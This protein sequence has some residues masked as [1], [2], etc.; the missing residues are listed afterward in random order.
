[1]RGLCDACEGF[2]KLPPYEKQCRVCEHRM[3]PGQLRWG[4][5]MCDLCWD[6]AKQ[7]AAT[8][9]AGGA[10]RRGLGADVCTVISAQLVFY[11]APSI[12]LPS[13]YLQIQAAANT[14]PSGWPQPEH[15]YAAVLTT[16]TVVSMVSPVPLGMW[17]ERYGERH[18]Y[19]GLTV[20]ASVAALL[21]ACMGS[22][23]PLVFALSW[24]LLSAPI[25]L[26]GVRAAYFAR[27][28]PPEELSR[29]G[30]LASAAGLVGSVLGPLL[31]GLFH[32]LPGGG[33][34]EQRFLAMSAC[35][36]LAHAGCA[37][38]LL[39]WMPPMEAKRRSKVDSIGPKAE[40]TCERCACELSDKVTVT[41]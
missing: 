2:E 12:L 40:R 11:L 22:S 41:S 25:S 27:H 9:D 18:V 7:Q 19:V 36:G 24:A 4:T 6:Q 1:M 32:S 23:H 13:L 35:A 8:R 20:T 33:D 26:R 34:V 31:A 17:A 29:V 28:V 5:G 21:L 14:A 16:T 38:A 30:Q 37:V 39:R 3:Q 15:T 10:M